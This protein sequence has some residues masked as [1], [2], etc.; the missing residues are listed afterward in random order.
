MNDFIAQ[1]ALGR[2][3]VSYSTRFTVLARRDRTDFALSEGRTGVSYT[4]RF[5][6]CWR[7]VIALTAYRL[8]TPSAR[9]C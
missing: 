4:T 6:V 7:A 2:T 3:G 5:P 8:R 9:F 1:I